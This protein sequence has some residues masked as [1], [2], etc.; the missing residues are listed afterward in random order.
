M[1]ISYF[2]WDVFP[3][4][5]RRQLILAAMLANLRKQQGGL[6]LLHEALVPLGGERS[7]AP[8]RD[9][10]PWLIELVGDFVTTAK[11]EGFKFVN[12]QELVS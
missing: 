8:A 2:A 9:H 11:A 5:F 3:F 1:P 12:P 7:P 10:R 6:F 4:P